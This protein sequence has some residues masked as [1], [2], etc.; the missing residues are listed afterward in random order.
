MIYW[1]YDKLEHHYQIL[2]IYKE[3][4]YLIQIQKIMVN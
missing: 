1:E 2:I 4:I 3:L